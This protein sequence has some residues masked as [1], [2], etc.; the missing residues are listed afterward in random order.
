MSGDKEAW[1]EEENMALSTVE[2]EMFEPPRG[3]I[4]G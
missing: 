4:T 3:M 2:S 1:K